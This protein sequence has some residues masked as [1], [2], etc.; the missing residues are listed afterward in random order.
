MDVTAADIVIR[1]LA[2]SVL[3]ANSGL[4]ATLGGREP[5]AV[6]VVENDRPV[7]QDV[8]ED[9]PLVRDLRR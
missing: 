5:R 8:S 7:R 4:D 9:L 1:G 3:H 2:H 6:C